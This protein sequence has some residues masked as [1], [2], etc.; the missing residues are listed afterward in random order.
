LITQCTGIISKE[1]S[2]LKLNL[3]TFTVEINGRTLSAT[4]AFELFDAEITNHVAA[5][6]SNFRLQFEP[7]LKEA[8]SFVA[9][10]AIHKPG[11]KVSPHILKLNSLE[12][13]ES[14]FSS[15][16]SQCTGILSQD[17]SILTLRLSTITVV[18]N[19]QECSF[20]PKFELFSAWYLKK[21]KQ[22]AG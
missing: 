2:L 9:M 7:Q 12:S 15:L 1:P 8:T 5:N 22:V 14:I 4:P 16:K 10:L 19:G 21:V 17:P 13:I 11:D 6:V 18:I 20:A 3:R